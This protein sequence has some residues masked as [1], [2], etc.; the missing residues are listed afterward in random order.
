VTNGMALP[1]SQAFTRCAL[2]DVQGHTDK[3]HVTPAQADRWGTGA[4]RAGCPQLLARK[5]LCARSSSSLLATANIA[6]S[7]DTV[8]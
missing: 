7:G 8:E 1:E 4:T 6:K 5:L 3:Q 2:S